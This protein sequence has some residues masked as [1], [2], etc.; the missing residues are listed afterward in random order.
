E[1]VRALKF[2]VPLWPV[3]PALAIAFMLFVIGVLGTME[4]TRVALYVGAG[5]VLLMSTAWYLRVKPNAASVLA[6]EASG[7]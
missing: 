2:K 7:V 6:E 3:G 5:W 1:E 4:D